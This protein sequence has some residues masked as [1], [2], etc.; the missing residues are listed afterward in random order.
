MP[1]STKF[2]TQ[3]QFAADIFQLDS[4][5]TIIHQYLPATPV[6]VTDVWVRAGAVVEP[7]KWSGMAHF[8]EHM[9]FK[10]SPNVMAGEFDSPD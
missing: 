1:K 7:G 4:G 8:L 10:G 9:I 5:L 2:P 6:V 3:V